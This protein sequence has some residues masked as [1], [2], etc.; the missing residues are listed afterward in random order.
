MV[1]RAAG[2]SAPA[3]HNFTQTESAEATESCWAQMVWRSA[4]NPPSR[5]RSGGVP[6]S[7]SALPN[8]GSARVS[9]SQP[10]RI[11]ASV[12]IKRPGYG[13]E[14][15]GFTPAESVP[16]TGDHL[17]QEIIWKNRANL[18][19]LKGKY[20]RIKVAGKNVIGY[21]AVLEA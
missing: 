5:R 8:R 9:Q 13:A 16:V 19:A 6:V 21:T 18:D 10:S 17:R 1:K 20:I 11:S 3:A 2:S 4:P 15:E 12:S 14:Y 7:S